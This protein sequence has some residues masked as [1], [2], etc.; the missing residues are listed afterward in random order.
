MNGIPSN[1]NVRGS[2]Q[3]AARVQSSHNNPN[4]S[5]GQGSYPVNH[6]LNEKS[7][8]AQQAILSANSPFPSLPANN[9]GKSITVLRK[10]GLNAG[11]VVNLPPISLST[12]DFFHVSP[13][14]NPSVIFLP[15][16]AKIERILR[17]TIIL[18][19]PRNGETEWIVQDLHSAVRQNAIQRND[20]VVI[21]PSSSG[22]YKM[23]VGEKRHQNNT[24]LTQ[25]TEVGNNIRYTKEKK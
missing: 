15:L 22:Y 6:A 21:Q 7:D 23:C 11:E 17:D 9:C 25:I 24:S 8:R 12:T 1:I 20:Q 14:N 13:K 2:E 4:A 16:T 19:D 10:N 3:Q 18:K 5:R